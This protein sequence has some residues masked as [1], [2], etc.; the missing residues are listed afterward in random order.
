MWRARRWF[1]V[2]FWLR[3][4]LAAFRE[5]LAHQLSSFQELRLV[6]DVA[7]S[8][9]SCRVEAARRAYFGRL[10]RQRAQLAASV[11]ARARDEEV[12]RRAAF[13][14]EHSPKK[15][16][17]NLLEAM[18]LTGN[19]GMCEINVQDFDGNLIDFGLDLME[20]KPWME[21]V[22]GAEMKELVEETALGI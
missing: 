11:L 1:C 2:A 5:A 15:L 4:Q 7:S 3:N 12:V 20:K 19:P 9:A 10:Y 6:R 18:G 14:S 22:F 21:G 8:Y 17:R 16:P 13:L